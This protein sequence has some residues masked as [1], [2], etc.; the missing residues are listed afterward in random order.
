MSKVVI[1]GGG[2]AGMISAIKAAENNA[3]SVLL[4]ESNEKLGKKL[5][6]TGKGRCNLTN[7]K[8][9]SEFFDY[10]PGNPSFLYSS[11]YSFDNKSLIEFFESR[12]VPL[13]TER[14][15]RI[16]PES[17]K[18]SDI[19]RALEIELRKNNIEVKL[20]SKVEKI[21]CNKN[22]ITKVLLNSGEEIRG[23]KFILATGGKSYSQTG[24]TG[25]G[26]KWALELGHKVKQIA[27]SL[28]PIE[29]KDKWI[30]ELQGLSLKNV[31]F[32][33]INA[34]TNKRIFSE[35]GEMIFTHYGVSGPIVLKGS[36]Y[37]DSNSSYRAIINLKPYYTVK[38]LNDKIL[39]IF[40]SYLNK[41]FK[42]SLKDLLP[43]KIIN[44]IIEL[45]NIDPEK[46]VNSITKKERAFL[47]NLLQNLELN[48]KGLR[49]IEEA[50]ITKGGISTNEIDPSTMKSKIVE[51][52][53][54]AGELIDVDAFTGGYNLQ[55]AFSTGYIAGTNV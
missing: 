41:N 31:E 5:F 36:R 19:I 24:S 20:N 37:I 4:I 46:K 17:N 42:N 38:E 12:G 14:G 18:S 2:P 35:F 26:Y 40:D 1:I 6:I 9:I 23:D 8:D 48:V 32:S 49:P 45:S 47:V 22:K 3:N 34:K 15:G 29:I 25:S 39:H 11:L 55:I 52:L 7:D 30:K 33:I 16:F 10:I 44:T 51:N 27:P 50:I 43:N 21:I 28:V 53:Y 13:K 54:F